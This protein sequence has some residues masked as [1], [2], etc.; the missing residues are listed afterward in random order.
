MK[1]YRYQILVKVPGGHTEYVTALV[2]DSLRAVTNYI[3]EHETYE[4]QYTF[5]KFTGSIPERVLAS[6]P[7]PTPEP[8]ADPLAPSATLLIKLGSIAV[9]AE[10]FVSS[11]GHEFDI[12]A[13]KTLIEDEEYKAWAAEM[14]KMAFL[15]VKR[16]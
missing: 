16:N 14:D 1:H 8:A 11:R 7:E 12:Y 10:E 6:E 2:F 9:H 3:S 13:L 4:G 5:Q 15:P